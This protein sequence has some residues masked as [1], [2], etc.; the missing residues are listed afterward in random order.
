MGIK[1]SSSGKPVHLCKNGHE[2]AYTN[3]CSGYYAGTFTCDY[4]HT[5]RSCI[6]GRYNCASCKFDVC[7]NCATN[8]KPVAQHI[9]HCKSGHPLVFTNNQSGYSMGTYTCDSCHKIGNCSLGRWNCGSCKYDICSFCRPPPMQGPAPNPDS[10]PVG[11]PIVPD[12]YQPG[13]GGYPPPTSYPAQYPSPGY[14]QPAYGNKTHCPNGHPLY[15]TTSCLGYAGELF[16]CNQC[17][18]SYYCSSGRFSCLACKYD[19]CKACRP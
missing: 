8:F 14:M 7:N 16:T 2:L 18:Q 19:L 1:T 4:C 11:S 13:Q 17:G 15:E 10:Y 3:T 12:P 6:E 9:N 5:A